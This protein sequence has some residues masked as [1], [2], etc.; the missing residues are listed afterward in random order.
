MQQSHCLKR[1]CDFDILYCFKT[2]GKVHSNLPAYTQSL[3]MLG[4]QV[5]LSKLCEECD[6]EK[7]GIEEQEENA[8]GSTQVKALQRNQHKW[9]DQ[10]ETQR[11]CQHPTQQTLWFQLC[12]DKRHVSHTCSHLSFL[13]EL[14][15]YFSYL[16]SCMITYIFKTLCTL[17]T[18]KGGENQPQNLITS[19]SVFLNLWQ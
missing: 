2:V 1:P 5:D 16:I 13:F 3:Y 10:R 15:C 9:E 6:N 19:I 4:L 8:I 11:C 17:S 14:G 18:F 7:G 12:T